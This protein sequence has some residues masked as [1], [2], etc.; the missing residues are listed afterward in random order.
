[1][2]KRNPVAR[3]LRSP[4]LQQRVIPDKRQLEMDLQAVREIIARDPPLPTVQMCDRCEVH[5]RRVQLFPASLPTVQVCARCGEEKH[6][7]CSSTW[8]QW[9]CV[10]CGSWEDHY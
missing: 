3:A 1:M 9:E 6:D 5:A 4:Q 2:T 8:Q 10:C 7:D